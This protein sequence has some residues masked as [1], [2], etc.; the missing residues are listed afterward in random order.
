MF[1]DIHAFFQLLGTE[2]DVSHSLSVIVHWLCCY[3]TFCHHDLV[4]VD[5][6]AWLLCQV[7]T[8]RVLGFCLQLMSLVKLYTLFLW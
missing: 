4:G 2:K 1:V 6:L 3:V 7:T 8:V 5:L